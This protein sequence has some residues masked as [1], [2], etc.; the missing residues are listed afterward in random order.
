MIY[1]DIFRHFRLPLGPIL[2]FLEE[3]EPSVASSQSGICISLSRRFGTGRNSVV[4]QWV[5]V[6]TLDITKPWKDSSKPPVGQ[7]TIYTIYTLPSTKIVSLFQ[8]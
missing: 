7:A 2:F 5:C 4:I 8:S 6:V 1:L 3:V